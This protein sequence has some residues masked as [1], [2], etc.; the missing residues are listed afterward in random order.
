MAETE[1]KPSDQQPKAASPTR[2]GM[3]DEDRHRPNYA[4]YAFPAAGLALGLL[5]GAWLFSGPDPVRVAD[6]RVSQ[7]RADIGAELEAA[8][9]EAREGLDALRAEAQQGID[10][11]RGEAEEIGRELGRLDPVEQGQQA[12]RQAADEAGR[13]LQ[14]LETRIGEAL[15]LGEAGEEAGRRVEA[16]E[17]R[18]QTMADQMARMI[19]R[20]Q[21]GGMSGGAQGGTSQGGMGQTGMDQSGLDQGGVDQSGGD[22]LSALA[23][24]AAE[25]AG[26]AVTLRFG[27]VAE[28]GGRQLFVS[29]IDPGAAE[30]G[31]MV[32]GGD[33]SDL[34]EGD[35]VAV[36]GCEMRLDRVGD[37]EAEFTRR[38]EGDRATLSGGAILAP[39]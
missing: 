37:G 14:Q 20:M 35:S 12:L 13:R 19:Q 15:D 7:A 26:E 34:G 24:A 21:S 11:L 32:I 3:R 28:V 36:G 22:R 18:V 2:P 16:L 25:P 27:E 5:L 4:K 30:V 39:I 9:G 29:R 23:R 10:A 1:K 17:R 8:R 31:V 6:Q 38:C 33:A